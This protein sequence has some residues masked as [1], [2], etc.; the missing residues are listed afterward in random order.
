MLRHRPPLQSGARRRQRLV[1]A[2]DLPALIFGSSAASAADMDNLAFM[3]GTADKRSATI[4]SGRCWARPASECI[5]QPRRLMMAATSASVWR[6]R[7][8]SAVASLRKSNAEQLPRCPAIEEL[9]YQ[10]ATPKERE[11]L[12]PRADRTKF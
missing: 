2:A 10:V 1:Q 7:S 11:M 6:T 8:I 4:I 5:S 9:G 12:G 3:S